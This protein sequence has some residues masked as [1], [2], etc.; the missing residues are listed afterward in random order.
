MAVT[1][2]GRTVLP[3]LRRQ[4]IGKQW[5]KCQGRP[6]NDRIEHDHLVVSFVQ[7][8][9]VSTQGPIG[10]FEAPL[11][12]R[13]VSLPPPRMIVIL[14]ACESPLTCRPTQPWPDNDMPVE[15]KGRPVCCS[16]APRPPTTTPCVAVR[17]NINRLPQQRGEPDR[18]TTALPHVSTPV[19]SKKSTAKDRQPPAPATI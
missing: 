3:V 9:Q 6:V 13:R 19:C 18:A 7:P 4:D 5:P 14:R 8:S 16:R 2:H 1:D 10:L 12:A 11:V 17:N 15:T